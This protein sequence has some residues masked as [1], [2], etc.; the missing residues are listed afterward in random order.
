MRNTF[1][2][3]VA[4]ACIISLNSCKDEEPAPVPPSD[5]GVVIGSEGLT[6]SGTATLAQYDPAGKALDNNVFQKANSYIM[7]NTLN[8]IY[9]DE[10]KIFLCMSGAG[11]VIIVDRM[12]FKVIKRITNLGAP[13]QVIKA[14]DTKYYITDWQEEGFHV[15]NYSTNAIVKKVLTGKG[16]ENMLVYNDLVFVA[17]GGDGM[18]D[19][20]L[21]VVDRR[22][23]LV[24][25]E[26]KVG[27]NPNSMQLDQDD[28]LW[29][30]C[31]GILDVNPAASTPGNLVSFDLSIDSLEYKLDSLIIL[32]SLAITDNQMR[33]VKLA[34]N[35]ALDRLYWLSNTSEANLMTHG[36]YELNSPSN[37]PFISG[38][39]YGLG[40]DPNQGNIYV[41]DP[42]NGLENGNVI[43][44]DFNGAQLDIKK[45]GIMTGSFGF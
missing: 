36:I 6:T 22:T 41:S 44:Y 24:I 3:L 30:L 27:Y 28:K 2:F 8:S 19:S 42:L 32:D 18:N 31:S 15:Y 35:P 23:D 11:E 39:F 29:V 13:R 40:V 34:I 10:D 43:R 45:V 14:G 12:T 21:T 7:G 33:P 26:I 4:L 1:S 17:N 38:S 5:P 20:I 37:L 25:K 9:M 16:P